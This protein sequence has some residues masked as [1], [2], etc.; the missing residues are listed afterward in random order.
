MIK[1]V[2]ISVIIPNLHSPIVDQTLD[3]ILAQETNLPYEIIVVGQDKYNLVKQYEQ[4]QFI[5]TPEPVGAAEA[6]NIGIRHARGDWLFFIDADCIAQPGWMQA[7]V[8]E[9]EDGWQVVGG[10]VI[11][12]EEPFWLLVYNLSMFY[13]QLATQQRSKQN[14]LPTLNL[15]VHKNV[16]SKV[17]LM[18]EELLRGQDVDWTSRMKLAGYQLLFKSS[19]AIEH[20]PKRQNL[21]ALRDYNYKS[22]YFMI[23]VR[24]RYPEIF[25]MPG[26]LRK[27][28]V[29][30]LFA[31]FIAIITTLKIL[32]K[33]KEVRSHLE[34]I[35]YIYLQKLSWCY[36]AADSLR[37]ASINS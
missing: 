4:V 27:Q 18:D 35:P 15:A 3:S 8:E 14:F 11:T 21:E 5:Q 16:I 19:A 20:L 36:G 23:K 2:K 25:H 31:P 12:P 32:I 24:H 33:T 17:G 37:E 29:W 7:F 34:I 30:K 13:G 28:F 22:G 6:R 10:G 9:F 1:P 26:L